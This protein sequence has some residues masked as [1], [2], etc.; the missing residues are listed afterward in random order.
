MDQDALTTFRQRHTAFFGERS[1]AEGSIADLELSLGVVLPDDVKAISQF[2]RGHLLGGVSH[3]S[4]DPRF[5]SWNI[6][7]E[8]IRLRTAVNLPDWFVVLAEPDESLIVLDVDTRAVAW[9]SAFDVSRLDGSSKMLGA[10]DIWPS[11]AA[12]FEYLLDMEDEE[13]GV[14]G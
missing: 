6:A 11:Y 1:L 5:A 13:R 10:T 2:F 4:F 9:C 8:T 12:F 7:E 14:H 3:Y